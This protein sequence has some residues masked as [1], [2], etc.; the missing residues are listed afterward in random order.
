MAKLIARQL[1]DQAEQELK[2]CR[3]HYLRKF[4]WTITCNTPGS[5]W[6]WRR[7]FTAEDAARH[8]RRELDEEIDQDGDPNT[9]VLTLADLD[10]G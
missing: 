9:R 2:D 6:L 4:G 1:I 5:F 10:E 7:D 8:K 3:E